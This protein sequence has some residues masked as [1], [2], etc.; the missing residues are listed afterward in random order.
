MIQLTVTEG[1]AL[2]SALAAICGVVAS[3]E[4]RRIKRMNLHIEKLKAEVLARIAVEDA[5]IAWIG[6]FNRAMSP[7]KIKIVL[8]ARTKEQ[9]GV[10]PSMVRSDFK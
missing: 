2:I 4:A 5:A 1:A 8:R 6:Q 9:F 10:K 7:Q 3:F